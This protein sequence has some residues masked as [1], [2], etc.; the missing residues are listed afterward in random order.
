MALHLIYEGTAIEPGKAGV[1]AAIDNPYDPYD[2]SC[3]Q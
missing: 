2:L 3:F 1:I